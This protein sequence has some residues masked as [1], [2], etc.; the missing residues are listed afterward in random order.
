MEITLDERTAETVRIYFERSQQPEIKAMLPQK[1]KTVE[2]ALQDF[3]DTLLPTAASFGRIIRADGI[4]VGDVWCY[5]IDPADAP[6]AMLSF[7]VFDPAFRNRGT[8]TW[9]VALFLREIREKYRI[10]SVGAFTYSEN[11]ASRRVLEKN[12]FSAVEEFVEDG[13]ASWYYEVRFD[14][15]LGKNV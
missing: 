10:G 1:A 15:R 7:C 13:R 2:E 9:A 12:G 5:C 11:G 6:N 8:A 14:G 3:R 4:Y